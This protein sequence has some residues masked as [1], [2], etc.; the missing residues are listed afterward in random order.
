MNNSF[1]Y[2]LLIFT[3]LLLSA[4]SGNDSSY[5]KEMDKARAAME[6]LEIEEA[7]KSYNTIL[8]MDPETLKFG[9]GRHKITEELLSNANKLKENLNKLVSELEA[10]KNNVNDVSFE[11]PNYNQVISTLDNIYVLHSKLESYAQSK[12]FKEIEE[13]RVAYTSKVKD[14]VYPRLKD[15]IDRGIEN[16]LLD[17]AEV[18]L[19]ALSSI[20]KNLP[21]LVQPEVIVQYQ[22]KINS[23]REK[24]ITFPTEIKTR[25]QVLYDDGTSKITL[26][27]EGVDNKRNALFYK[28]EGPARYAAEKM[29]FDFETRVIFDNGNHNTNNSKQFRFYKDYVIG[30]QHLD[31]DM[32]LKI[33][34]VDYRFPAL[35][36]QSEYKT[37]LFSDTTDSTILPGMQRHQTNGLEIAS[38]ATYS[39]E[40]FTI[41]IKK[42]KIDNNNIT[43]EGTITPKIDFS[44][45]GRNHLY[46][47]LTNK[48]VS[49][50]Y[51]EEFF[52]DIPKSFII[53]DKFDQ[54]ISTEHEFVKLYVLDHLFNID[55]TSGNIHVSNSEQLTRQAYWVNG[56]IETHVES[57]FMSTRF[58]KDVDNITHLNSYIMHGSYARS[59]PTLRFA[60]NKYYKRLSVGIGI[61]HRFASDK[62]GSTKLKILGD[63]KVLKEIN[64]GPGFKTTNYELDVTG[65]ERLVFQCSYKTNSYET[66][67]LII[68][69]GILY[70]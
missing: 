16:L 48:L 54:D 58:I 62:Y 63:D 56:S 31:K 4:C 23:E 10:V 39:N 44:F 53:S 69:N 40:Q 14:I 45:N 66:Q 1:K 13:I 49:Q 15:E 59:E 50:F 22:E 38:D 65:I 67:R 37:L 34:R 68:T 55:L 51:K 33:V 17:T 43:V 57:G 21:E 42:I 36:N 64:I 19:V 52:K 70:Q 61:D 25:G 26:L 8:G 27:G 12:M 46:L 41:G 30:I 2:L 9:Y 32:G 7:V 20:S 29:N 11:D 24:Y 47:P 18:N 28:Y 6:N 5:K 60:L 35:A 3:I